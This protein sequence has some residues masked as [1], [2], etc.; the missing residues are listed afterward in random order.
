MTRTRRIGF[1]RGKISKLKYSASTNL[2]TD[3][4]GPREY[5]L[6]ANSVFDP[7]YGV[8]G[9]QP[10]GFDQWKL[11]YTRYTVL[12]S[13]L[14]VRLDVVA[15]GA[16]GTYIGGITLSKNDSSWI[17]WEANRENSGGG[18]SVSKLGHLAETAEGSQTLRLRSTYRPRAFFSLKDIADNEARIGA[19]TTG[20]PAHEALWVI[21]IAHCADDLGLVVRLTFDIYFTVL[22]SEPLTLAMS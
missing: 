16:P 10:L 12:K 4:V 15:P 22:W 6:R 13:T 8:G 18:G 21:Y 20:N 2:V 19:S 11:M 7:V 9:H 5:V 1:P 3:A 17:D 14:Y